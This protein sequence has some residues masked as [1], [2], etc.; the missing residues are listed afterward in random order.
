MDQTSTGQIVNLMS[1]DVNRF[2]ISLLYIPFVWIGPLETIVAVYFIWQE[3]GVSS[4][5]GVGTLVIF[6]PLQG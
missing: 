4:L 5:L 3:V 2:D 6:I 1:N